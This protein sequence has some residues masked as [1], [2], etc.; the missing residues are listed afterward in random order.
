MELNPDSETTIK[1]YGEPALATAEGEERFQF[2]RHGY[3]IADGKLTKG[4]DKVFNSI[5]GLKSSW[6]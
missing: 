6:K 3:Y 4:K 1:A 5:V 2:F